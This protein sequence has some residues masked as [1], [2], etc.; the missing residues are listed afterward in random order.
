M[1]E[2]RMK[3]PGNYSLNEN[4]TNM[5]FPQKNKTNKQTNKKAKNPQKQNPCFP[6]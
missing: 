2:I 3:E 6:V 1:L 4:Y 5:D